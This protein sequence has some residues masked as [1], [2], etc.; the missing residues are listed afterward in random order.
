MK[1]YIASDLFSKQRKD[2][3]NIVA[4]V[5]R[6]KGH[7]VF[8]PHEHQIENAHKLPNNEWAK[9]VFDIDLAELETANMVWYICEGMRGDIGSAWECG[10]A[11]GRNIPV[12]V[13]LYGDSDCVSLMVA[14]SC[15][16]KIDKYQS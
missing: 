9:L 14:Q 5:L 3:I 7:E 10:F 4:K 12:Y 6:T 13:D 2:Y 11:V 8:V 15:K 16:N 1:I